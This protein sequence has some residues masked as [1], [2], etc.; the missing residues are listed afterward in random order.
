M[1]VIFDDAELDRLETD[2]KFTA[3]MPP[4]VIKAYRK[5]M[6]LIRAALDERDFY[7]MK[8]LHFEKLKGERKHQYSMRINDQYR[9]IIELIKEKRGRNVIKVMS[10]ED[11]H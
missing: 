7:M 11:Y 2:P 9:L 10:I 4:Q 6:Q 1:D 3:A 8:S 5:K